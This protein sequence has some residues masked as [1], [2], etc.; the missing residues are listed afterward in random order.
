MEVKIYSDLHLEFASFD[1]GPEDADLVIL[2]GD[3]HTKA[4]GVDWANDAF[5]CPVLYV[6]GNH[7]FYGGHLEHTL[8][9]MKENA[10]PHVHVLNNETCVLHNTCFLCATAWTDFTLTSNAIAAKKMAWE[11]MNDYVV[12]RTAE[13]FRRLRPDD[14]V[15]ESKATYAWLSEELKKPFDGKTVVITH[16]AP[17]PSGLS[18]RLGMH[19]EAAYANDWPELVRQTDV[20]VYGHTHAAADFIESGCRMISNPRGYPGEQTGFRADLVVE[21]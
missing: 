6:C 17:T 7:E 3:I 12:I 1:P 19:L 4:R 21:I 9:K 2:A 10:R 11:C 14:L 13:N 8:I 5:D 18:E 15:N 20:W 16:H